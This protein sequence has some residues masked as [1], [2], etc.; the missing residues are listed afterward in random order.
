MKKSDYF[1]LMAWL[2]SIIAVIGSL[3]FSEVQG[4]IPCEWCWYQRILMYPLLIILGIGFYKKDSH[5][6]NY[7]LPFTVLGMGVALI[8]YLHQKTGF[9][10]QTIQ[11]SQGVPCSGQYI[12]WFGFIT[13]PFL[14]FVAFLLITMFIIFS[15]RVGADQVE[16]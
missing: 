9:F 1:R 4:F 16:N 10:Q 12:N 11:C 14:S 3:Y 7:T 8:H 6:P 15:K 13:I 2:V 5:L